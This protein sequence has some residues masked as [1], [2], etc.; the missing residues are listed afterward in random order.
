MATRDGITRGT[1]SFTNAL[2]ENPYLTI[3]ILVAG[4]AGGLALVIAVIFFCKYC[5]KGKRG[6]NRTPAFFNRLP[7]E[8]EAERA[9]RRRLILEAAAQS[10]TEQKA[11]IT[12]DGSPDRLLREDGAANGDGETSEKLVEDE[13]EN[14]WSP[15]AYIPPTCTL[16]E[17]TECDS[18]NLEGMETPRTPCSNHTS[19][20]REVSFS[21]SDRDNRYCDH[22]GDVSDN[23]QVVIR[24]HGDVSPLHPPPVDEFE[25]VGRYR[26]KSPRTMLNPGE[27][28]KSEGTKTGDS[29]TVHVQVHN[30]PVNDHAAKS[31][32]FKNSKGDVSQIRHIDER[33]RSPIREGGGKRERDRSADDKVP[34]KGDRSP[35][36]TR[37][38]DTPDT[39]RHPHPPPERKE[40]TMHGPR[41]DGK[42]QTVRASEYK[43][44]WQLRSTLEMQHSSEE[45]GSSEY[46]PT[47]IGATVEE[48][49]L[50]PLLRSPTLEEESSGQEKSDGKSGIDDSFEQAVSSISAEESDISERDRDSGGSG[51]D[52]PR[53]LRRMHGDSGYA[54]IE[55]KTETEWKRRQMFA[56]SDHESTSFESA[57]TFTM[58]SDSS[59]PTVD[60]PVVN[61]VVGRA[62]ED[63]KPMTLSA[64]L[65]KK[66]KRLE[67]NPLLQLG[68]RVIKR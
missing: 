31:P 65:K 2:H 16:G 67:L 42:N 66:L 26:G 28:V 53:N 35:S 50:P 12:V 27:V 55:Q 13:G 41:E 37:R 40:P 25:R 10:R 15:P 56:A 9:R 18:E 17:I 64:F 32:D 30:H 23:A 62:S 58:S 49:M 14:R 11:F 21:I 4:V 63:S 57:Q 43:D 33:Q 39:E 45:S 52:G 24:R 38:K 6:L 68:K 20:S 29:L 22:N 36:R 61:A 46:D 44:L 47:V 8:V 1:G 5:V 3:V 51:K 19:R 34:I 59:S 7:S 48:N 60:K 54:S